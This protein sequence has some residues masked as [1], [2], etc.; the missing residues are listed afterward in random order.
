MCAVKSPHDGTKVKCS[1]CSFDGITPLSGNLYLHCGQLFR[2]G[3]PVIRCDAVILCWCRRCNTF[4]ANVVFLQRH[5]GVMFC[6][7]T[8]NPGPA[9]GLSLALSPT[10]GK[11]LR[12]A[13]R[14]VCYFLFCV[15]AWGFGL[16]AVRVP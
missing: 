12:S 13:Y 6:V 1:T 15:I 10:K 7:Y 2:H 5:Q 8:L 3:S 16:A 14:C 11:M 4:D 9:P